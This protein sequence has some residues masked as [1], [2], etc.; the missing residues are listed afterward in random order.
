MV[1]DKVYHN[2]LIEMA[3]SYP[4]VRFVEP[5]PFKDIIPTLNKFDFGIYILPPTSFN[6]AIALP[7]KIFEFIQAKLAIAIGPSPE[8]SRVV[9]THDLGV[10]SADF[11]AQ[12]LAEEIKK[13]SKDD[14]FAFKQHARTAAPQISAE[15]YSKLFLEYI[16]QL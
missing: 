5:V 2:Q 15:H 16:L 11:T 9:K 10:I 8:M 6:N 7:N 4:N 12:S 3:K 1:V 14:I 13:L